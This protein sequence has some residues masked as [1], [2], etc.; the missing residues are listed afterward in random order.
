MRFQIILTTILATAT[1]ASAQGVGGAI[2]SA[3]SGAASVGGVITSGAAGAA[4]SK[5][6]FYQNI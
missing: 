6:P 4:S 5:Y 1:I 2:S 3:I